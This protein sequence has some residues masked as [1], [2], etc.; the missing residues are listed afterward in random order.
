M[1]ATANAISLPR[2]IAITDLRKAL[3]FGLCGAIGGFLGDLAAEPFSGLRHSYIPA[4]RSDMANIVGLWFAVT[5]AGIALGITLGLGRYLRGRI[6]FDARAVMVGVA[7]ALAGFAAG[8]VAQYAYGGSWTQTTMGVPIPSPPPEWFRILC[9]GIAGGLLGVALGLSLPNLGL[10]RGAA[11]GGAGGLLGGAVFV[12][13]ITS[14]GGDLLGRLIGCAAIGFLIGM[15]IVLAE[16]ALRE[17]WLEIIFAPNERRVVSLGSEPI[18]V[19]GG[20]DCSVVLHGAP[21]RAYIFRVEAGSVLAEDVA[22][23]RTERMA[24]GEARRVGRVELVVRTAGA[25]T[26]ATGSSIVPASP[27]GSTSAAGPASPKPVSPNATPPANLALHLSRRGTVPLTIG[28]RLAA[29][30]IP[31]LEPGLASRGG[32]VAEVAAHPS[33]PAVL[34]LMNLSQRAWLARTPDGVERRIEPGRAITLSPGLHL[35]FG[36]TRGEVA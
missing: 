13:I 6:T 25:V 35:D 24:A 12:F 10:I 7:G 5:G 27:G 11:G 22:A 19:G 2:A 9:W 8:Y 14:A 1:A 15:M 30:D 26:S 3:F 32:A 29:G 21:D 17:A 23:G 28:R 31:G 20:R 18:S 36:Q 4:S 33:R 16:A 34:G